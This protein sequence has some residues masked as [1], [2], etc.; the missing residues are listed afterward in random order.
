M[1]RRPPGQQAS[2]AIVERGTGIPEH[3]RSMIEAQTR[4]YLRDAGRDLGGAPG[5]P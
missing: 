1:M 2:V 3:G 4:H 5:A